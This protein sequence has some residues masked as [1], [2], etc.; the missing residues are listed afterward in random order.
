MAHHYHKLI[1]DDWFGIF[2]CVSCPA[3][4]A[5]EFVIPYNKPQSLIEAIEAMFET[6]EELDE[7]TN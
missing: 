4:F 6:Q 5:S 1:W 2:K 7:T 3:T